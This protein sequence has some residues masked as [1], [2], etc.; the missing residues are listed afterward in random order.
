MLGEI[1][2]KRQRL[3]DFTYMQSLKKE[4]NKQNKAKTDSVT[5]IVRLGKIDEED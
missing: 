3:H 5:N 1:R 2:Q 4:Q